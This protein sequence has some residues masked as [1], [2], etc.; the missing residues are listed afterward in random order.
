MYCEL[1]Y[2]TWQLPLPIPGLVPA[3][4]VSDNLP[5]IPSASG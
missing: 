3:P 2:S 4:D 1:R 5:Q